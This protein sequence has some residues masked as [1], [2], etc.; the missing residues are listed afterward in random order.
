MQPST[1]HGRPWAWV[2]CAVESLFF[3]CAAS[4][5]VPSLLHV[6][7]FCPCLDHSPQGADAQQLRAWGSVH[8]CH[9][10]VVVVVVV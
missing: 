3:V 8:G 4:L 6:H 9:L 10:V 5:L 2:P 1:Q 7:V